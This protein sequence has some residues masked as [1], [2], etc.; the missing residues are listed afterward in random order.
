[1]AKPPVNWNVCLPVFFLGNILLWADRSNFSV[2]A[3]A[4]GKEYSWTPA[5]MGALL[6]AFSL[7]Y[8]LMQPV[9]GWIADRLGPRKTIAA[10]CAGWSFWVLL[11][12]LAV[13]VQPLLA[14]F[15]ALLGIFEAPYTPGYLVAVGK[16]IPA[17]NRRAA[18]LNFLNSG[19]YLGPAIGVFFAA[20]I[21]GATHNPAMVFVIFAIV[22]FAIA[23]GWWL[24]AMNRSDP[25]P[26]PEAAAT[27]EA[28]AREAE[29]VQPL[30]SLIF[31][32]ALWPLFLSWM[33]LPYCNYIFLT[34]LPQYLTRYRHLE[35][36]QAGLLASIPFFIA[37]AAMIASGFLLDYF[38]GR[39]WKS[40]WF[41]AHRKSVVYLG[42]LMFAVCTWI[43]STTESTSLAIA[44][45][46]VA[47][48]GLA[49]YAG[50]FLAMVT[51]LSPNQAGMVFGLMNF[52]GLFGGTISP[53][54][55][56]IIAERTGSFAAPLQVSVVVI[57]LGAL[58]L[59]FLR[60]RPLSEQIGGP[61][62]ATA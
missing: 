34:W 3:A 20:T 60:L 44:M 26:S 15:R 28:R 50:P 32:G 42:A 1:M 29:P 45:I 14:A 5:V 58:A 7:G 55:S 33:A 46:T 21:L 53:T 12:P 22:G 11:T 18:P 38:A 2:A 25:A 17:E 47:L 36:V 59:V 61:V 51:D 52:C 8:W 56:G 57:L 35:V 62:P 43:A 10:T 54:I 13:T 23:G 37:A 6:S 49:I 48:S 19:G 9:G 39:G 24:Y 16:A 31:N 30:R 4:W 40:G 27:A 41:A